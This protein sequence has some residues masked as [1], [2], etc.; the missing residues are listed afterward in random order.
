MI[1]PTRLKNRIYKV[2][3]ESETPAG[4]AFDI[5]LMILIFLSVIL[6]MLESIEHYMTT[7]ASL[8]YSLNV[9]ITVL[10]SLE[11]LLRCLSVPKPMSY[12]RSTYGIID[13]VAIL[14]FLLEML[15]PQIRFL[16]VI[17]ILRLLR[18]FRIFKMVRFLEESNTMLISLWR[19][20]RKIYIFLFFI[21]LLTVIL[22]SIMY[23]IEKDSNEKF[24][25]I[26]QSVYW[27]I[28]TMTTVGYGDISPVTTL[29]KTLAS[30]IMILGYAIIAVPTGI[31]TANVINASRSETGRTCKS[32]MKQGHDSDAGF[33]KYCGSVI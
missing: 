12:I 30:V 24:T 15:F 21:L 22:G 6:V 4:K 31:I 29:G 26:P 9:I 19:S 20:R 3:F 23:V 7:Y 14:P 32:C 16:S 1:L 25:S 8:F 17:R 27:A 28:V 5:V 11:Y 18:I 2:I 13:L 33:C 10:F